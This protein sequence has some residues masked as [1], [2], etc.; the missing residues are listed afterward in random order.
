MLIPSGDWAGDSR[1]GR[2]WNLGARRG[3]DRVILAE[4]VSDLISQPS[5]LALEDSRECLAKWQD[6]RHIDDGSTV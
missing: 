1:A 5:V 4:V 3:L 2:D 6:S